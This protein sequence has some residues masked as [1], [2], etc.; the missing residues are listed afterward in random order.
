MARVY[1]ANAFSPSMLP[2][3]EGGAAQVCVERVYL[4]RARERLQMAEYLG[5]LDCA[6]GH[7]AT[8]RLAREL[9]GL[10][11]L[12]CQR[13]MIQLQP[14]DTLYVLS[15][16]FRPPEGRIYTFEELQELLREGKIAIWA[17][18]YGPC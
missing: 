12:E 7:E 10:E 2:L 6:I 5:V 11:R 3:E 4:A 18:H 13:K 16:T 14:G 9:L 8:A 15:L 17:V 1:L